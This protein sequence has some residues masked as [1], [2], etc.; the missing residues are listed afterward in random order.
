MKQMPTMDHI[1]RGKKYFEVLN[2][3]QFFSSKRFLN[4]GI[5]IIDAYFAQTPKHFMVPEF[6]TIVYENR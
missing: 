4:R 2:A 5:L 3:N 1:I 6:E